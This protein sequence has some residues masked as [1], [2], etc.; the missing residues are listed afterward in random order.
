MLDIPNQVTAVLCWTSLTKR[1]NIHCVL[2]SPDS[3]YVKQ[4]RGTQ[5]KL[6][7]DAQYVLDTP[8]RAP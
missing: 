2:G 3:D 7:M 4:M 5:Y 1:L 6:G 8:R